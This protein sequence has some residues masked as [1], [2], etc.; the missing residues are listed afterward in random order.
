MSPEANAAIVSAIIA[1]AG[2][3]AVAKQMR[4]AN[5]QREADAL[6]KIYDINRELLTLGFSHPQL[7]SILNGAADVDPQQVRHYLQLWLNQMSLI[8]LYLKRSVFDRDLKESLERDIAYFMELKSMQEY[9]RQYRAFYPTSFQVLVDGIMKKG[10]PPATPHQTSGC[11]YL[12]GDLLKSSAGHAHE[13]LASRSGEDSIF[14]RGRNV[15]LDEHVAIVRDDGSGARATPAQTRKLPVF[16]DDFMDSHNFV[17]R[18]I[19]TLKQNYSF[20]CRCDAGAALV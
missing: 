3:L 20:C 1:F 5:R 15:A 18:L 2:L 10:E 4:D 17:F 19:R 8:H 11:E 16:G 7:F 13:G 14:G 9:W 6:V 12:P